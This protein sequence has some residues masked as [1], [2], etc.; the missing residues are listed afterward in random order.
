MANPE[1]EHLSEVQRRRL[2]NVLEMGKDIGGTEWRLYRFANG[3][4]VAVTD[5]T[6]S[7]YLYGKKVWS[8]GVVE[9][10]GKGLMDWE[11][12][13]EPPRDFLTDDQLERF[14][15]KVEARPPR[16]EPIRCY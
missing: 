3:Y 9:L 8:A 6:H 12:N 14:L 4:G 2:P 11:R 1:M 16:S 15:D 5:N 7:P 10:T 13:D